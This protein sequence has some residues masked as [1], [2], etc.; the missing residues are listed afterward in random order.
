MRRVLGLCAVTVLMLTS[1]AAWSGQP[2]R[3]PI[4]WQPD[5]FTAHKAALQDGKPML[6][7]FGAEWCGYCKKLEQ[8]TLAH[9][10]LSKYINENFVPVHLDLD[11]D[12]RVAE[13][14]KVEALPCTVVISPQ[15]DLLDQFVGYLEAPGYYKKLAAA[16]QLHSRL[17][18][19][20]NTSPQSR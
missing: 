1:G 13:I 17:R 3:S 18:Q 7:V 16:E 14:L 11:R 15:A 10:E 9:P 2:A 4:T 12:S 19:A 6:L 5:I 8:T 20:G